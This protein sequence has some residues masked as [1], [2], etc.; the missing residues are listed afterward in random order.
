M[1]QDKLSSSSNLTQ[2][3]LLIW[4]GQLL[5]PDAPLYNM[6]LAFSMKGAL[7]T[8]H[9]QLALQA[10]IDRSD[11]LRT[12]IHSTDGIPQQSVL[13]TYEFT[14]E[15]ID[16]SGKD[17]PDAYC[18]AWTAERSRQNFNLEKPMF[19]AVLLKLSEAH[20]VWY[21][22]QHHL[23]TDGWSVTLL[24]NKLGALYTASLAGTLAD[25]PALPLF[26]NYRLSEAT[27]R[28][29]DHSYWEKK[30][31]NLPVVPKL[32]G[33]ENTSLG[34][35]SQR[36][37]VDLGAA[38]SEQLRQL[39]TEPDLRAWTQHLSLFNIFATTLLAY[40]SRV[41]SQQKL[42]IGT[43]A[44]NRITPAFKETA[45]LFIEL[46][47][48]SVEIEE[49][50][51][52]NTLF[53]K[54]QLEA[55]DFLKH[56]KPGAASSELSRRFNV[57]LNY[58]N[59]S[60]SDFAGLPMQSDWV[61]PD[62]ADPGHSL[63]LQ[64][65]DFDATGS[66]QLHFDL[67]QA[68]FHESIRKQVSTHFLCILDAFISD[69]TALIGAAALQETV[70]PPI[71]KELPPTRGLLPQIEAQAAQTPAAIA[72]EFGAASMSFER[73][74]QAA[75]Q[76]ARYLIKQ[77]LAV[78]QHVA[79]RLKRS[80]ELIVAILA[81][82]KAGATYIPVEASF[83]GIR[84][85]A[86]IQDA[87]ATM[88]IT[89]SALATSI[90][91]SEQLEILELDQLAETLHQFDSSNVG[92]A[93]DPERLAYIMYTS[94]STGTPKGVMIP[95]R[96]LAHYIDW[97]SSTY[98]INDKAVIPLFT[99][100]GFDLTV[101][102]LFLSL[103]SG[104]KMVIYEEP[105]SGPDLAVFEVVKE[106]KA[107]FIKLTP[108]HLALLQAQDLSNSK[109]EVM[110]VGGEELR[111]DLASSMHHAFSKKPIIYNEYGPTEAT[112]GCVVHA[113]D[114]KQDKRST[115]PIGRAISGT[116]AYVLDD[117]H[118]ATPEGVAGELYI[119]GVGL[120]QGYWNQPSL[121]A[122]RFLTNPFRANQRMYRTG[123]LVR[124]NQDG[125]LE[126][127]GRKDEQVKVGGRRIELGEVES[128]LSSLPGIGHSVV[129]LRV[130]LTSARFHEV[131][132]CSQC[133][134][135][136]NYPNI[137]FDENQRCGLC[138]SF[139]SYQSRVQKYFKTSSDLQ[140]LFEQAPKSPEKQYDCIA[141]LSG[142]KD[143]TYALAKLIEMGLKVLA[144]TL[145]NGYISDQAKANIHRVVDELKVD[146]MY[147]TTPAMNEIFV[148]SLKR[149][150]NVCDGCFKTIYTLSMQV[151]LEK[152]IP[153]IVT[154]LSRGQFFETRLTEELFWDDDADMAK[155]D[156]IIL[157][158]RKSY[159][160]V[161]D[162]VKRLL[163][164]SA[165]EQDETFEKVR[166]IDYYRFTDVSLDEMLE[167][168]DKR[169]PWSRPTDTGRS[170]NCLINQAGIFVHK[171]ERGYSNYAFP[172]SW[173]VR[174]GHKTR[175]ASLDEINEEINEQEVNTILDEIGYTAATADDPAAQQ[176]VAYYVSENAQH[177]QQI[178]AQLESFLPEYMIPMQFIA[179]DQMPLTA[180]GKIN[181]Q[182]LPMPET[183][184]PQT[185][186]GY[187]APR[188]DIEQILADIWSEVLNIEKIGV[189][190][191]FL[192]VGGSSLAA[193][194]IIARANE[195]FE[196]DLP[197]N[198]AFNKPT[199]AAF[200]EY[201]RETIMQMLEKLD[202][203]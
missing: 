166:F 192:E 172:Y 66:I 198:L 49:E 174:L 134:L 121:T 28:C 74:N 61:H 167:Y 111:Y 9:F 16:F 144:F 158:A 48:L 195:M 73:L 152:N 164:V 171:K 4:T 21:F 124:I 154:G 163:D 38:R 194:R 93:P 32:Y 20:H 179:L 116:A 188:S 112:V 185:A 181:K 187:V 135:P 151:A 129:D 186:I 145:D 133:G 105:E 170:T 125:L 184:R 108:A 60:F 7:D 118:H 29:E 11:A 199:I 3:Q 180:N 96:A 6:A 95:H 98:K 168:L 143:S 79:I 137:E 54:V 100:I 109:L 203:E 90:Q 104:G 197:L 88:L 175:D 69:R 13:S 155:I 161:D 132:N 51:R 70:A 14:Q 10:L 177:D 120:A 202:S 141:L 91:Q 81:V 30:L 19:D 165:F 173:D 59:A 182:A 140:R 83:S 27:S 107:S 115:V 159:H 31:R 128:A 63:R 15:T 130:N 17:D 12:V 62:H 139:D 53:K 114:P 55:F 153:F 162:A 25:A 34:S 8:H 84:A 149:H 138:R 72:L 193:I 42:A 80:P 18:K 190:D 92:I 169:L 23:I 87:Q 101:T 89:N 33:Y 122:D 36:Y 176:L 44:H 156:N 47:P 201:V 94:G 37:S 191:K 56:A 40:L 35:H 75:N 39:T 67:N 50:E 22:N 148:D 24:Y 142:G 64:V 147:G 117:F 127:L 85:S 26:E 52:F 41:S 82:W 1:T 102:S 65:H 131:H 78:D 146:H 157:N 43:P 97:A 160:R 2:S 5:N 126:Y 86:M 106:N 183:I 110:V 136:S 103:A 196:L 58:I 113:F 71:E 200:S 99:A 57:V 77:G 68:V 76:L 46:F 189:F 150:K 119:A 178:R 45:G 123:D